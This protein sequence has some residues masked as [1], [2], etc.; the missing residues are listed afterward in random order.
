MLLE[1]N[2]PAVMKTKSKS[3]AVSVKISKDTLEAAHGMTQTIA[4]L[5]WKHFGINRSDAAT[6][7]SVL[8]EGLKLLAAKKR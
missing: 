5:G 3:T 2:V 1:W 7:G 4:K 8:D 6:I